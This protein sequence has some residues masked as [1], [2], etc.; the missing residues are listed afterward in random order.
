MK[1]GKLFLA[2]LLVC[3]LLILN[4]VS[5]DATD[6]YVNATTGN[7]GNA[8]TSP[9]TAWQTIIK[10]KTESFNP[11]DNIYF[12]RGEAWRS[13][14][15]VPSSGNSTDPLTFRAYGSGEKPII[16]GANNLT[17]GSLTWIASGSGT[18]E[19]YAAAMT[20]LDNY[21]EFLTATGKSNISNDANWNTDGDIEWRVDIIL[22]DWT[23]ASTGRILQYWSETG[24]NRVWVLQITATG[25]LQVV[26]GNPTGTGWAGNINL[27][28]TENGVPSDGLRTQLRIQLD[29]GNNAKLYSRRGG[30]IAALDNND[31]W[32]LESSP[33]VSSI[34]LSDNPTNPIELFP[35][36]L[37]GRTYRVL[38]WTDLTKTTKVL[39]LDY[40][41]SNNSGGANDE[42]WD[43]LASS[44]NWSMDGT[45]ETDWDYNNSPVGGAT[46]PV[47]SDPKQVFMDSTRLTPGTVGSLADHEW[48]YGDNDALGFNTTYIRDNTGDPDI[49]GVM[50]EASQRSNCVN[51]NGKTDLVFD[52]LIVRHCN[53]DTNSG[54]FFYGGAS[55]TITNSVVHGHYGRGITYVDA[56][57]ESGPFVIGGASGSGNLVYDLGGTG[58][59]MANNAKDV[60]ISWNEVYDFGVLAETSNHNTTAGIDAQT[61]TVDNVLIEYNTVHDGGNGVA[62]ESGVGI[63]SDDHAT[64]ITIRYNHVYNTYYDGIRMELSTG[65]Q[66]YN[67]IVHNI[68]GYLYA[69]GIAVARDVHNNTVYNNVV[70]G[71]TIGL[72]LIGQD[73][74]Q[75]DDVTGN[76]FKNN[77]VF[78]SGSRALIASHGGENDGTWGYD[79][80]FANNSFGA[81]ATDF[82]QWAGVSKHTY[83]AWETVYGG[84]T[85]S[86]ETDPLMVDPDNDDFTLQSTS[87]AIDAGVNLGASYDDAL[88]PNSTWPNAVYTLDQDN[89]GTGWEIGAYIYEG[90]VAPTISFACSPIT[91]II[92][93]TITCSCSA[94]DDVDSSPN[95]SYT[96]NPSTTEVGTFTTTCTATDDSENSAASSVTYHVT[97]SG[98]AGEPPF[99]TNTY[100][101]DEKEF[102]EIGSITKSLSERERIR[103]KIDG[104]EH[105]VGILNLTTTTANIEVTSDP[106]QVVFEI[107]DENKFDVTDNGFYDLSVIL[108]SIESDK[109]NITIKSVSDENIEVL[110]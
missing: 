83:D 26:Y 37:T 90:G 8:G 38:M 45:H 7:D 67:N 70:Y 87:P 79:N 64:N 99:Y 109:A 73:P 31:N 5:L 92:G 101:M 86:V 16:S 11:G 2:L 91:A 108:N 36:G 44:N 75:S 65:A 49:F 32:A 42:T 100:L 25:L 60:V 21:M 35:D 51:V 14:L 93:E 94:T 23:P 54:M 19:Y 105:H 69:S 71:S 39:D 9:A 57:V 63:W 20:D 22:D 28:F 98:G 3:A 61:S 95:V 29:N 13:Q 107:G 12:E 97:S 66:C 102:S 68:S 88:N 18:N 34:N 59:W 17:D 15:T 41:D 55:A 80:V 89:Y 43:D 74:D 82:V 53:S 110:L 30:Y 96:A 4:S 1:R 6:Y 104:E 46:D 58:I 27:P 50:I 72:I 52:S 62:T 40:T 24:N 84:S 56:A 85:Y 10:V 77:I 76:L 33:S 81:E 48:D 78:A 103:I 106:Q 47:L